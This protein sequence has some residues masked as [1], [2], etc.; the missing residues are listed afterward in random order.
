MVKPEES[1]LTFINVLKEASRYSLVKRDPTNKSLRIHRLVREI[2]RGEMDD[3]GQRQWAERTVRAVARVFPKVQVSSWPQCERLLPHVQT[4]A[5]FIVTRKFEF[6]EA[7]QLLHRSGCYL[8]E[9]ARYAQAEPL[10]Q[11]ALAIREKILGPE[12]PAV[13]TSLN[14]LAV[15]YRDQGQ[16]AQAEPLYQRALAIFEKVLGPEHPAI[17][18]SLNNLALL[19]HSQEQ[20]AQA[21]PLYQRALA[22]FEKVLGPEHPHV[23]TVLG[24][25]A[26]L[27][28]NINRVE[29]TARLAARA[30]VGFPIPL[31]QFWSL[32]KSA[33][34]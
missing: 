8:D 2:L 25:R 12:H 23:A 31:E 14:S 10:Y 16:Y 9:R 21:E 24:N 27:L 4:C 26:D 18:T 7:A 1:P 3:E 32:R 20:Y 5:E 33:G 13:A 30:Q 15:L 19:Y 29:E 17:A 6:L 34:C 22:I 11:R 28:W